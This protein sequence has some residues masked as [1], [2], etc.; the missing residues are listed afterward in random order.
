MLKYIRS[1]DLL[2]S[3]SRYEGLP[4]TLIEAQGIRCTNYSQQL[5]QLFKNAM[6][7]KLGDLFRVGN[8]NLSKKF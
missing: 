5:S 4:N 8:I 1:S 3:T 6:N 2:V 7:G